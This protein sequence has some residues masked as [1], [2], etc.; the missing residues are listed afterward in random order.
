VLATA[1]TLG[2]LGWRLDTVAGQLREVDRRLDELSRIQ[3]DAEAQREGLA[4]R[5]SEL[6]EATG[7]I[8][9]PEAVAEAALPSVFKVVAGRVTGSAFAVG[10]PAEDGGTNLF[11]N[12]HV[13]EGVWLA[14][15]RE[16]VLE[17][18]DRRFPA[19]IVEVAPSA[20]VAWLYSP[21]RFTGLP[22]A[23][24]E[25]RPGQPVVSVGAPL[26]LGET[27]TTG[28]V[29]NTDRRL[30]DGTGPWIQFDAAVEPGNS[31][32]PVVDAAGEVVGI[33][34]RKAVDV[35]G[36]GFAVPIH[37]ACRLFDVCG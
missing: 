3:Q 30:P 8:F 24:G 25:L 21:D 14:G 10:P 36:I 4:A 16:V 37:T 32:G 6:E 22:V 23:T 11:T 31:G 9:D 7:G 19:V 33:T 18:A 2:Y 26:G 13:V 35:E 29:S 5:V 27:V 15:G 28:V 34:T 17:Q 12:Y 20:D 1:A